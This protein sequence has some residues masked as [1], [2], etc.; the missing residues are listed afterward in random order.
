MVVGNR[1]ACFPRIKL[2]YFHRCRPRAGF[3]RPLRWLIRRQQA[4]NQRPALL[5]LA[6]YF[7]PLKTSL[8]SNDVAL[9]WLVAK[10]NAPF[11]WIVR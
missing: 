5:S 6:P 2:R 11:L 7:G 3:L 10:H 9:L 1:G 8:S 4:K